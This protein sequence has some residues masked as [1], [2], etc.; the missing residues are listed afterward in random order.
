LIETKA[1][2]ATK[3]SEVS[4]AQETQHTRMYVNQS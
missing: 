1:N 2:F 4:N 3:Q